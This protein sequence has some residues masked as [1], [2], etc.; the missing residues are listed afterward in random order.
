M[1]WKEPLGLFHPDCLW[2]VFSAAQENVGNG[3]QLG[4]N[5]VTWSGLGRG[6]PC[7]AAVCHTMRGRNGRRAIHPLLMNRWPHHQEDEGREGGGDGEESGKCRWG[8]GFHLI[9]HFA[10]FWETNQ[11]KSNFNCIAQNHKLHIISLGFDKLN[12]CDLLCP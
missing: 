8:D 11:I 1:L 7:C 6:Q 10:W 2:S 3:T 9:S 4:D 12:R 5:L